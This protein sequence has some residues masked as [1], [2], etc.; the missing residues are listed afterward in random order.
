MIV[1]LHR[2]NKVRYYFL[3]Y[4]GK[5]LFLYQLLRLR[6]NISISGAELTLAF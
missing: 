4:Y 2:K 6:S 5:S 1:G 3:E